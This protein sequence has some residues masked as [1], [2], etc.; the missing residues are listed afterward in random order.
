M[1][2]KHRRYTRHFHNGESVLDTWDTKVCVDCH[3]FIGGRKQ[4]LCKKCYLKR[5][6]QLEVEHKNPVEYYSLSVIRELLGS[7]LPHY[8]GLE[9]REYV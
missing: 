5:Q 9:L 4:H 7:S 8:L 6:Q 1:Q 3:Q 2:S